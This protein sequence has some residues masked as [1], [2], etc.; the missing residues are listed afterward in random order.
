MSAKRDS[1]KKCLKMKIMV[2][3]FL[4]R[5]DFEQDFGKSTF[6]YIGALCIN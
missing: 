6:R 3:F 2:Y 1:K 4:A 5:A